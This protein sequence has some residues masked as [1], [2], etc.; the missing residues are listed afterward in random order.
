[1]QVHRITS[2][3]RIKLNPLWVEPSPDYPGSFGSGPGPENI[4]IPSISFDCDG[5]APF[6]YNLAISTFDTLQFKRSLLF[7]P[8][9]F[10]GRSIVF[11]ILE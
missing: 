7:A 8:I 11:E 5:S 6:H 10:C 2:R 1:M 4:A 3:F 9:C